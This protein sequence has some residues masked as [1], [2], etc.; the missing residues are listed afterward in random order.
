MDELHEFVDISEA[1]QQQILKGVIDLIKHERKRRSI[2]NKIKNYLSRIKHIK[3]ICPGG[4]GC[5]CEVTPPPPVLPQKV[6][7]R[8]N[9][10]G[11]VE[12]HS[13]SDSDEPSTQ[14]N[15]NTRHQQE[16][17]LPKNPTGRTSITL[18]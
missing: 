13:D 3:C 9:S 8:K 12:C 1:F 17:P 15:N 2:W 18:I 10:L 4:S 6:C 14:A 11:H 5:E 16:R 7:I